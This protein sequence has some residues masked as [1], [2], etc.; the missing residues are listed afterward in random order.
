MKKYILFLGLCVGI[1]CVATA[2]STP[3]VAKTQARQTA[4]IAD[5]VSDGQLTHMESKYLRNQQRQIQHQKKVAKAD[6]V[7]TPHERRNIRHDQRVAD[8]SIRRQKHDLQGG[9]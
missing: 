9:M 7:V 6:G 3:K 1:A 4:R 5:G 2:Q 8:R